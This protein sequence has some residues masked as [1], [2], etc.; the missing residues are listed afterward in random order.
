M[1]V[2]IFNQVFQMGFS[3]PF[4]FHSLKDEAVVMQMIAI[5]YLTSNVH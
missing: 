2:L 4:F 3:A 1:R 5:H